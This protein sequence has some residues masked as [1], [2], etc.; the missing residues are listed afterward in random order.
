MRSLQDDGVRPVH[1]RPYLLWS[2]WLGLA[3]V[4]VLGIVLMASASLSGRDPTGS[5]TSGARGAATTSNM[6]AKN[7]ALTEEAAGRASL[8]LTPS[9]G[10]GTEKATL[11]ATPVPGMTAEAGRPAG[12]GI[13]IAGQ[14]GPFPS[15]VYA[16]TASEWV[17]RKPQTTIEVLAGARRNPYQWQDLGA[18]L[19]IVI[20]TGPQGTS[21]A[22]YET[23]TKGELVF[24][25]DAVGERLILRT[26]SGKALY[27]DV[28][29]R[30]FVGSL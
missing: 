24:I 1:H 27:F 6:A 11:D 3:A 20:E 15:D 12:A 29:T 28:P 17:E 14:G 23:A 22:E 5:A 10:P 18:G 9:S 4:I 16:L 13:V 26:Q 7:Q 30:L 21:E 19:I 25:V 2:A 8:L